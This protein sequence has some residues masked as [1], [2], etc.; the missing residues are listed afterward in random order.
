[1]RKYLRGNSGMRFL[2]ILTAVALTL[3]SVDVTALASAAEQ[4]AVEP[5][6][7]EGRAVVSGET[8]GQD[9]PENDGEQPGV[10]ENTKPG[11]APKQN[12]DAPEDNETPADPEGTGETSA[13]PEG[14]DETSGEQKDELETREADIA[15]YGSTQAESGKLAYLEPTVLRPGGDGRWSSDNGNLLWFGKETNGTPMQYRILSSTN[16]FSTDAKNGG[17]LLNSV[18]GYA[19]EKWWGTSFS[20]TADLTLQESGAIARAKETIGSSYTTFVFPKAQPYYWNALTALYA[21]GTNM[22]EINGASMYLDPSRILMVSKAGS[23]KYSSD[24]ELHAISDEFYEKDNWKL[25]LLDADKSVKDATLTY[26][27]TKAGTGL[28]QYQISCTYKGKAEDKLSIMVTDKAYNAE[29]AQILCY[30]YVNPENN[31]NTKQDNGSG[32]YTIEGT[33]SIAEDT[34][35][36]AENLKSSYHMYLIVE[37]T[38]GQYNN[39]LYGTDYASKPYEVQVGESETHFACGHTTGTEDE[40][41]RLYPSCDWKNDSTVT[42]KPWNRTDSLPTEAGNYYL[43]KDVELTETWNVPT[44]WTYLCLSG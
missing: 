15:I 23:M 43:V 1:M 26:A 2:A 44:G 8:E 10:N 17:L 39:D 27:E 36:T 7:T 28:G 42:F 33:F 13:D 31:N 4:T 40:H 6:D 12:T 18:K 21:D 24:S 9:E 11:S 20:Y 5:E 16:V 19:S 14:T 38:S 3:G 22:E 32:S 34:G 41:R 35:V 25:T 30:G 37:H 29:G